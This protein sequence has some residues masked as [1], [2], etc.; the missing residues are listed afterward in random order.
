[1]IMELCH[2]HLILVQHGIPVTKGV[3]LA[4]GRGIWGWYE[5]SARRHLNLKG[6]AK[7]IFLGRPKFRKQ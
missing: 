6:E 7:N 2:I 5:I 3:G 1:M 4:K